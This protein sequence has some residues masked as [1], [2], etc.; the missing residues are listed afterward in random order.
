MEGEMGTQ[1]PVTPT[2][3]LEELAR[4]LE[5]L[6]RRIVREEL[7]EFARRQPDVFRLEPGS[8]LYEDMEEILRRKQ[9]GKIKLYSPAETWDE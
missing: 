9:Q 5:P 2:V 1:T 8:P 6:M 4:M 3:S 7:T